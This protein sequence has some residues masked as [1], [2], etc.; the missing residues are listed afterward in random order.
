MT[1]R[2][3][4]TKAEFYL[5]QQSQRQATIAIGQPTGKDDCRGGGKEKGGWNVGVRGK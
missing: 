2:L 5:S 3:A 1:R 4:I